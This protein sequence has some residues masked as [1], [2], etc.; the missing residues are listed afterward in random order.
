MQKC[1][2]HQTR[3]HVARGDDVFNVN[4]SQSHLLKSF[5]LPDMKARN[6]SVNIS[7]LLTVSFACYA[8]AKPGFQHLQRGPADV[9]V[10]EKHV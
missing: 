4:F 2:T 8:V 5:Y 7:I 1:D 10:S 9:N 6:M 3:I